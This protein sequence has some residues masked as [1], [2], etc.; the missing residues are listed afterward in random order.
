ML[1]SVHHTFDEM[2]VRSQPLSHQTPSSVHPISANE[3]VR[4][5]GK[6]L[7][8]HWLAAP[9]LKPA[10]EVEDKSVI[11]FEMRKDPDEM[12]LAELWSE[13]AEDIGDWVELI[14]V[15]KGSDDVVDEVGVLD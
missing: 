13:G 4:N 12:L 10:E 14:A 9:G 15:L 5:D 3:D 7:G 8:G 1:I 6:R 11:G 2:S